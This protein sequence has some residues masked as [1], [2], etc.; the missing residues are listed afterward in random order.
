VIDS[1]A[2]VAGGIFIKLIRNF[3]AERRFE[4]MALIIREDEERVLNRL[5]MKLQ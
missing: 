5:G 3:A 4:E 2:V 1:S